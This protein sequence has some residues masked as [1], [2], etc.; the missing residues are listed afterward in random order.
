MA[1]RGRGARDILDVGIGTSA[2]ANTDVKTNAKMDYVRR[3]IG[4]LKAQAS[5]P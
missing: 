2:N 4:S 5:R 1:P 3:Q